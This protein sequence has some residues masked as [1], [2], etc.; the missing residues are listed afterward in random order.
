MPQELYSKNAR[1]VSSNPK[2]RTCTVEPGKII[3]LSVS[4]TKVGDILDWKFQTN[5]GQDI[6][7]KVACW[8][9]GSSFKK[10]VLVARRIRC[11]RIPE[12]GQIQCAETGT[13]MFPFCIPLPTLCV[14]SLSVAR[15]NTEMFQY[16]PNKNGT[17]N[18][19]QDRIISRKCVTYKI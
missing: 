19:F 16:K 9:F 4:V 14:F 3:E 15:V 10:D 7:F 6:D 13:C 11:D 12:E 8:A 18:Y 2:S 17:K 5:S 1:N